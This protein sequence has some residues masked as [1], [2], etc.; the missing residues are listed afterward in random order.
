MIFKLNEQPH[1]R[2]NI[3][4]GEWVLVS[5]HR[6]KRPWSGQEEEIPEEKLP[7]YDSTCYLCPG[8]ERANGI[9]NPEY[10]SVYTFTNDFP[11]LLPTTSLDEFNSDNLLI[12]RGESGTCKVVCFSPQHNV[13]LPELP[14]EQIQKVVDIWTEEYRTYASDLNINY[15]QIF[16]NKG[17]AMGCSNPHPHSQ[18]WAQNSIP[19]EPA[20]ELTQFTNYYSKRSKCLL[21][22]YLALEQKLQERF[23]CDN[24]DFIVIVPFWAVWPF[25]TIVLSKR[26]YGSLVEL[27]EKEKK[28]FADILKRLTTKY[29]NLFMVSFPY[30]SGIHQLPTDKNE[31]PEW[32]FHMHFYPPLL[33][34]ATVKK[35]MVGYE[36]LANPQR[37][38]TAEFSAERL[39]N[40]SEIHH[41]YR[42]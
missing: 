21:C 4:S 29:D 36:M 16:E 20:K 39:R 38:I 13:T 28:S 3:L 12:A 24:E 37:D 15:V 6:A 23:V 33:R 32:H 1:R 17:E 14:V 19:A 22:D 31:H 34:S 11:A 35:F 2:Y 26:H 40:C 10:D 18:I 7:A 27:N 41:K 42:K 8:N 30:S 9:R 25:E 5:P